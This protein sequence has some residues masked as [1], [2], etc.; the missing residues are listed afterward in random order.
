MAQRNQDTC[1]DRP[2]RNARRRTKISNVQRRQLQHSRWERRGALFA[3]GNGAWLL[4]VGVWG[5]LCLCRGF[6]FLYYGRS[7]LLSRL[8]KAYIHHRP[9]ICDC[10]HDVVAGDF[11]L[12]FAA[13][14]CI[15]QDHPVLAGEHIYCVCT[16]SPPMVFL[17]WQPALPA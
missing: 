15:G 2:S 7:R 5:Y 16:Y 8:G 6:G 17:S 14:F 12:L 9:N 11:Q 13:F 4:C 3:F 10:S 1:C